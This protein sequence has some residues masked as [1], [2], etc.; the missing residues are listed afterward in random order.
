M[1]R[2]PAP[3][4][5]CPPLRDGVGA[6]GQGTQGRGRPSGPSSAGV[7]MPVVADVYS[8]LADGEH[9]KPE[10]EL[11]IKDDDCNTSGVSLA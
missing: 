10:E 9:P 4:R 6:G 8:H 7:T 2:P 3:K 5:Q 1:A 11:E